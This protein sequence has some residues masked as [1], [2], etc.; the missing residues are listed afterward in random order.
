[1]EPLYMIDTTIAYNGLAANTTELGRNMSSIHAF[2][3]A[4]WQSISRHLEV[5]ESTTSTAELLA[6]QV[7]LATLVVHRIDAEHRRVRVVASG[8]G[9]AVNESTN[10][11]QLADA[12]WRKLDRW[13]KQQT[14]LHR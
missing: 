13:M 1:M 9:N 5:T 12:S 2:Q 7:P 4:L 14:A 6:T 11:L 3:L 8:P 10:E